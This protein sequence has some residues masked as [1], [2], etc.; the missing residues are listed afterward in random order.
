MK[1]SEWMMLVPVN[2]IDGL[3]SSYILESCNI[4]HA[5]HMAILTGTGNASSSTN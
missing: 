5:T 1:L 3:S 4:V 2:E